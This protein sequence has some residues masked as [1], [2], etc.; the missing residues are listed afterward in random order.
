MRRGTTGF[1]PPEAIRQQVTGRR[2]DEHGVV[3]MAC[4]LLTG[5]CVTDVLTAQ[6]KALGLEDLLRVDEAL[7]A[8]GRDLNSTFLRVGMAQYMGLIP[9]VV[10]VRA[11]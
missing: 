1:V 3:A 9:G 4:S 7:F 5:E 8:A 2:Y 6:F 10:Q 11:L